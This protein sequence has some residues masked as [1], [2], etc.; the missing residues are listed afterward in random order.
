MLLGGPLRR[1]DELLENGRRLLRA[2]PG[3]QRVDASEVDEA[4]GRLAVFRLALPPWR[5]RANRPRHARS[6]VHVF[7]GRQ[8]RDLAADRR[9]RLEEAT[10]VPRD[11]EELSRQ[12]RRR[13]FADEDLARLRAAFHL[14]RARDAVAADEELPVRLADEEE[15]V[16]VAVDT[17]VHPQRHQAGGGL[18]R[19]EVGERTPHAVGRVAGASGVVRPVEEEQQGVPAELEQPATRGV[20][21]VEQQREHAVHR[22][23]D[24][25]GTPLAEF[26]E[27]LGHGREAGDVDE[28]ERALKLAVP[29]I[30]SLAQPFDDDARDERRQIGHR[31]GPLRYRHQQTLPGTG[32]SFRTLSHG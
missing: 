21:D 19:A 28:R 7:E 8:R 14:D 11:T 20:P 23:E 5:C 25:L 2:G 24:L 3:E 30:R 4:D 17:D 18:E 16:R 15:V 9:R 1:Y 12:R 6:D 32:P 29:S 27:P 22:H 26:G 13:L 31:R 10:P